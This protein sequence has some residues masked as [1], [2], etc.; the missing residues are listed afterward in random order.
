MRFIKK[1]KIESKD[2][3][4]DFGLHKFV[5][6]EI[7]GLNM[8]KDSN[9]LILGVGKGN[10]DK[11]LIKEGFNNIVSIDINKEDYDVK[12]TKFIKFDLN[13]DF[14]F[15]NK[16]YDLIIATELIEHLYSTRNFLKNIKNKLSDDGFAII[17]T[18]N[19]LRKM[20]RVNFIFTGYLSSFNK[21]AFNWGHINPI[22]PHIFKY[23]LNK[24]NFNIIK[25]TYNRKDFDHLVIYSWKSYP[26]YFAMWI[27]SNLIKLVTFNNSYI[28]GVINLFIY[29][30]EELKC[31]IY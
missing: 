4:A 15:D 10:L 22:F 19:I 20:S 18:P 24:L 1:K 25:E 6:N 7:K 28:E 17:T 31:Q 13:N 23:Y 14:N 11:I 27:I 3:M 16:K 26:Y 30:K 2:E 5:L 12:G 8:S 29:F 9:I 21:R